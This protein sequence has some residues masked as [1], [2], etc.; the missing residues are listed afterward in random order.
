MVN[1]SSF[2]ADL[3]VEIDKM[4]KHLHQATR[5]GLEI[6]LAEIVSQWPAWSYYSL[7]NTY[8]TRANPKEDPDPEERPTQRDA[9]VNEAFA[10]IDQNYDTIRGFKFNKSRDTKIYISN[11]VYYADD[12]G[13]EPGRGSAIYE[14]A[15][16]IAE[17]VIQE[18]LHEEIMI[19]LAGG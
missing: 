15:A 7:R 17:A 14:M 4:E 13:Y 1:V 18:K 6:A 10:Q 9:L 8:V 3:E 16:R 11:P 5:E 2:R 12:V 19:E